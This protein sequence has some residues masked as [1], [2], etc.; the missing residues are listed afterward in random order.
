[1]TESVADLNPVHVAKFCQVVTDA[2][3]I[4]MPDSKQHLIHGRLRKR[5]QALGLD[6]I[7]A[8]LHFVFEEGNL[9]KELQH[10][11]DLMSTNRTEF[12]REAAHMRYLVSNILPATA[13]AHRFKLWSAASSYGQE[14]YSCAMLLDDHAQKVPGFQ[15][16]VLGTDISTKVLDVAQ[17]AEYPKAEFDGVPDALRRRYVQPLDESM[18]AVHSKITRFVRFGQL[19]LME[20]VYPVDRDID[21]I[22]LRNVLIY[23]DGPT[24]NR[25]IGK[26]VDHL[27]PRG[28]LFVGHAESMTVSDPR[29]TPRS[30]GVF[31]KDVS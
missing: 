12:F 20:T 17:K 1:M 31:Q 14:A 6:D 13:P 21:V 4:L 5:T 24:R 9:Q 25:V 18:G 23:F 26:M 27:R 15:Y 28:H 11:I 30:V 22:F 2:T 10:I 29:L 8:Y 16:G 19:N 7:G 3:G